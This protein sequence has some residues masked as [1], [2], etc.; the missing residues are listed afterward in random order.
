VARVCG[1]RV[2]EMK[3]VEM[4]AKMK[5]PNP[6]LLGGIYRRGSAK[7]EGNRDIKLLPSLE[8]SSG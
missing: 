4:V 1:D 6:R 5:L 2:E 7:F 3:E 8:I